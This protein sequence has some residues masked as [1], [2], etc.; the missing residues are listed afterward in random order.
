MQC[1]DA[2]LF[3]R[4]SRAVGRCLGRAEGPDAILSSYRADGELVAGATTHTDGG[5]GRQR[6][7]GHPDVSRDLPGSLHPQQSEASASWPGGRGTLQLPHLQ[8]GRSRRSARF[9]E[10]KYEVYGF[11]SGQR[12]ELL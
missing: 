6:V 2:G 4:S 5:R 9:K 3:R 8:A 10:V 1:A 7:S 11:N 12:K